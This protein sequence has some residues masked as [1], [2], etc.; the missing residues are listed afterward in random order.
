M[1]PT[2]TAVRT[3]TGT[4][5]TPQIPQQLLQL[6][7]PC[8]TL[9]LAPVTKALSRWGAEGTRPPPDRPQ[10]PLKCPEDPAV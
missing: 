2:D 5:F 6:L 4:L 1:K 8:D 10:R 7:L 9:D 3:S